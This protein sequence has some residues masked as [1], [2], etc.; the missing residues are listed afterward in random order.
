MTLGNVISRFDLISFLFIF[1]VEKVLWF[2]LI[3]MCVF[4]SFFAIVSFSFL[5]YK[6]SGKF[7]FSL[8]EAFFWLLIFHMYLVCFFI[9]LLGYIQMGLSF[10]FCIFLSLHSLNFFLYLHKHSCLE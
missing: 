9:G 1:E 6:I 4:F 2:F 7:L 5:L 8:S 10:V 3:H